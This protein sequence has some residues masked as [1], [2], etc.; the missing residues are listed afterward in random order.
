MNQQYEKNIFNYL[1]TSLLIHSYKKIGNLPNLF[2]K[3]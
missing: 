1:P 3:L 2:D